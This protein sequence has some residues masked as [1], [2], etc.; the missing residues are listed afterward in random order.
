MPVVSV[1][2]KMNQYGDFFYSGGPGQIEFTST[3]TKTITEVKTA[4]CDPSGAPAVLSPNS[5]VLYKII[6]QNNANLNVIG[7][8]MAKQNKK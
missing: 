6:K 7:D 5:C 8:I 3:Q 4:I 1:L 2:D